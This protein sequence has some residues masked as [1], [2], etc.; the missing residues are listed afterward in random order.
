MDHKHDNHSE[1]SS[2][3]DEA[4]A[5]TRTSVSVIRTA[6]ADGGAVALGEN[7]RWVLHHSLVNVIPFVF[8]MRTIVSFNVEHWFFG[9]IVNGILTR[10]MTVFPSSTA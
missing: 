8:G 5:G 1:S 3:D 6:S 7:P 2:S 10:V 4:E 9:L